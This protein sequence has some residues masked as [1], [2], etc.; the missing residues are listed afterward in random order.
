MAT[1]LVRVSQPIVR[2]LID[3]KRSQHCA[4]RLCS[5]KDAVELRTYT[6]EPLLGDCRCVPSD[7]AGRIQDKERF[8]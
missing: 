5:V 7:N 2:A 3:T 1:V 6:C 8:K 4:A